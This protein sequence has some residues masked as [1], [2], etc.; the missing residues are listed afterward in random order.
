M[1]IHFAVGETILLSTVA[2]LFLIVSGII[3][4]Q[5]LKT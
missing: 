3:M 4:Q 1:I 5:Y 2:G